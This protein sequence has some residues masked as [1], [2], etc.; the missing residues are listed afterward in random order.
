[1]QPNRNGKKSNRTPNGTVS[2][3][4]ETPYADYAMRC[5]FILVR[6]VMNEVERRNGNGVFER[7]ARFCG[8]LKMCGIRNSWD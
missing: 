1:M 7:V 2:K 8:A 3:E 6:H 5:C 4:H